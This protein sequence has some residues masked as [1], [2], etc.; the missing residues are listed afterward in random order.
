MAPKSQDSIIHGHRITSYFILTYA[1]SWAGAFAIAVPYWMRGKAVPLIS[2]LM[3][4]PVML[5]GPSIAGIT[6]TW[7]CQGTQGLRILSLHVRRIGSVQWLAALAIPPGLVLAVLFGLKT[8][9]SPVFEPN[10]FLVGLTFGCVAGFFEEIG[11]TGFA[12]PTM[13][14]KQNAFKAA[15]YSGY[16]GRRGMFP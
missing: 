11:W 5:F 15:V 12:F 8:F 7:A 1:I 10:V 13:R 2:G 3:M 14:E 4:F 16:C 9:V 6:L